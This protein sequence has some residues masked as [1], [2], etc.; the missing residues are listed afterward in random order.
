MRLKQR[1]AKVAEEEGD[2]NL[3]I[4]ELV[5]ELMYAGKTRAEIASYDDVFMSW[6]LC[7]RRNENGELVRSS[8]DLPAWVAMNLDASGQWV[9]RNPQPF[10]A[11][12][13]QVAQS[14]GETVEQSLERWERW[15]AENPG[16][17]GG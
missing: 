6:V 16:Y 3:T 5:C 4:A 14:Q 8:A 12:F 11:M 9:V 13:R 1:F 10:G 17:D 7:R 15:K 2:G